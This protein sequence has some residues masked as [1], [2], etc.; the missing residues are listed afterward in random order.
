MSSSP[1][2]IWTSAIGLVIAVGML[3]PLVRLAANSRVGAASSRP[4]ERDRTVERDGERIDSFHTTAAVRRSGAVDVTEEIRYDF[5]GTTAHGIYRNIP[6]RFPYDDVKKGYDRLTPLDLVSVRASG[7]APADTKVTSEPG[8]FTRIRIGDPDESVNGTVTYR[9]RYRLRGALDH[10]A[11]HDELP[12]DVVGTGWRVPIDDASATIR[13]PGRVQRAACYS[14]PLH[15]AL[16]CDRLTRH[17]N[18]VTVHESKLAPHDAL[19]VVAGFSPRAVTPNPRPLLEERWTATRAFA[20]RTDTLAPMAAELVVG[21][22]AFLLLAYWLGRDRQ[23]RGSPVDVAYGGSRGEKR[24]PV[25]E[26]PLVPV[27]FVPPEGLRPGQIG[28]VVFERARPLDVTATIVDFAARGFLSVAETP[29]EDGRGRL[30]WTLTKRTDPHGLKPY[31]QTIFEGLFASGEQVTVSELTH[32]FREPLQEAER[33]LIDDTIEQGWF[34]ARPDDV[35]RRWRWIG[36]AVILVGAWLTLLL[37]FATSFGLM[38]LPVLLVGIVLVV[39]AD[40]FPYRT[41]KGHA[42]YQHC[43]GF[44]RFIEESEKERARFAEEQ[45]LFSQYLPYVVVF[46]AAE[47]WAR[48]FAGFDQRAIAPDWYRGAQPFEAMAFATTMSHFTAVTS[49]TLSAGP[50]GHG[51]F[52]G[53]SG[54][55]FS[56]GFA[57]GGFGGGGG[58][59]W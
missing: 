29:M 6:T 24:V 1:R 20:A 28:T 26:R 57:G 54:G 27:E 5:A 22:S 49:G 11:G 33:Q 23:F 52:G 25:L 30:D 21:L 3:F 12:L 55:G 48:A 31:E 9:I 10:F 32:H 14:G 39:F 37:A 46:G 34:V 35:R 45:H 53:A 8:G 4:S 58:G 17:T 19:T 41:A 15:S 56:G 40:R 36:L 13:L 50:A 16:P 59:S 38:G 44:R 51:G 7:G 18:T 47:Q 43:L 42:V 2:W